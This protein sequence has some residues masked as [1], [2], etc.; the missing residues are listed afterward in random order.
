[1]YSSTVADRTGTVASRDKMSTSVLAEPER[2]IE[3]VSNGA[4]VLRRHADTVQIRCAS[5]CNG[6]SDWQDD[7]RQMD[8]QLI[9][10]RCYRGVDSPEFL[11][12]ARDVS[13]P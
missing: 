8:S 9:D 2:S 6:R 12:N 3:L 4:V 10:C 5:D 11:G 13:K 7:C 1:M